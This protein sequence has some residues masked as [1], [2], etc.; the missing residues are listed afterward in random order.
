MKREV[1]IVL[2]C[3]RTRHTYVGVQKRHF[4]RGVIISWAEWNVAPFLLNYSRWFNN[5]S[6]G[7]KMIIY[8][9]SKAK[10]DK[11]KKK[12]N[13]LVRISHTFHIEWR[14]KVP[15]REHKSHLTFPVNTSY[16]VK[17]NIEFRNTIIALTPGHHRTNLCSMCLSCL[18]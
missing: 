9:T 12:K 11:S 16:N 15:S 3:V 8:A 18:V 14:K 10:R 5:E 4:R 17:K 6:L 13:T 7:W 1:G 2:W